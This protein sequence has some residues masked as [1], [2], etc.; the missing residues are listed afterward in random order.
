MTKT[1]R[2]DKHDSTQ[3]VGGYCPSCMEA[4]QNRRDPKEMTPQERADEFR[5]WGD[6]LTIPFNDFHKRVEE[7]V[8]RSVWTHEFARPDLL[9]Q[10]IESQQPATMGEVLD[11]IPGDKPIIILKDD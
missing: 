3:D 5:W 6:I 8:G 4:F 9:I 7:L 1:Y 11:K 10:E 2:C